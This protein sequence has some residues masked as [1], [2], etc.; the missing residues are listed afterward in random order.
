MKKRSFALGHFLR[1]LTLCFL[2]SRPIYL[3]IVIALSWG[4]RTI[5]I[6]CGIPSGRERMEVSG[7]EDQGLRGGMGAR[8]GSLDGCENMGMENSLKIISFLRLSYGR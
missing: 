4:I 6:I 8:D 1:T 5:Q 3:L 2:D 7:F